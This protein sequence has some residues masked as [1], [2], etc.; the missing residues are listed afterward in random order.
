MKV[1]SNAGVMTAA[2]NS[3]KGR[4]G[5]VAEGR[6][7]NPRQWAQTDD[8]LS[9]FLTL[10][11]R[12]DRPRS[13]IVPATRGKIQARNRNNMRYILPC[14]PKRSTKYWC[15]SPKYATTSTPA[16]IARGNE[17]MFGCEAVVAGSIAPVEA[18]VAAASTMPQAIARKTRLS[19][20]SSHQGKCA[21]P[22]LLARHSPFSY[23]AR[24]GV[25][26]KIKRIAVAKSAQAAKFQFR[27]LLPLPDRAH[28]EHR[29][30]REGAD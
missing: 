17:P 14:P 11:R 19:A 16:A 20:R 2:Q 29:G 10:R 7:R 25:T 28:Q 13:T 4:R 1:Y 23:S 24:S 15:A 5:I 6:E 8:H 9:R 21:R 26:I 22:R 18:K 3:L 27:I 30:R 12:R